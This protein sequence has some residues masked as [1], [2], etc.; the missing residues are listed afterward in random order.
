[1]PLLDGWRLEV[2]LYSPA[3]NKNSI[4]LLT[5]VTDPSLSAFLNKND[6]MHALVTRKLVRA[7]KRQSDRGGRQIRRNVTFQMR[8]LSGEVRP[9]LF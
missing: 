2:R 7:R 8:P 6:H 9:A 1:M 4:V 3:P 5:Y